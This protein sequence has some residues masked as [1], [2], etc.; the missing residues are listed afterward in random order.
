MEKTKLIIHVIDRLPELYEGFDPISLFSIDA[1]LLDDGIL[2][3]IILCQYKNPDR[4][5]VFLLDTP[6]TRVRHDG[7][8]RF[9][10][11]MQGKDYE[12][13]ERK[14]TYFEIPNINNK[15]LLSKLGEYFELEHAIIY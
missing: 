14:F 8:W 9:I 3:D 10:F 5:G 13:D 15:M 11:S 6:N 12:Y 4:V 7:Q 2:F 1:M